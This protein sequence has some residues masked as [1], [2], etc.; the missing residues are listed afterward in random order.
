MKL[1]QSR[2]NNN[3]V[4]KILWQ[5]TQKQTALELYKKNGYHKIQLK[6]NNFYDNIVFLYTKK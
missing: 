1:N 3:Q 5:K 4:A 6:Y 2:E